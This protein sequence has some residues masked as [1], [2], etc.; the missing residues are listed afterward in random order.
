MSTPNRPFFPARP[1]LRGRSG[2]LST[3]T[4]TITDAAPTRLALVGSGGSGKSVLAAALAHAL[5]PRFGG[6]ID[7][8]RVGAWDF[9]TLAEMLALRFGTSRE[10]HHLVPAL[11]A[12]LE[13]GGQRLVVL[14][15]HEDD[16]AMAR[17]LDALAGTPASFVITARRCLLGGV[18]IFPVTAPQVTA[19]RSAFPRVARLT[20]ALRWN[21]LAL[22]VADAIVASQGA[23][24]A[25]LGAFLD[26]H[27]V[28]RVRVIDHEDD[29]P[30]VALL[31]AWAWGRLG[32]ESRRMIGVLAHVEGDHVDL[33]SLATLARTPARRAT[34]ALDPLQRWRLV[35]EPMP[36]RF[37][38]H[39]V[40]RHAV[41]KRTEGAPRRLFEHYVGLLERDPSRLVLEQTHLFGAMD[42]AHRTSDLEGMLRVERLLAQLEPEPE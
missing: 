37:A 13:Q 22:D 4:R 40:V 36:G 27:G 19:G 8:F 42:Y 2:E 32:A 18:L 1:R 25:A 14:D 23:S 31:V 35:Q 41:R 29:L 38:L 28:G 39:A 9:R 5:A 26:A 20:R 16:H 17:L 34:A 7:W 21:P 6:R 10:R 12:F 33:P 30:E 24:V 11:R 15:N 3:L